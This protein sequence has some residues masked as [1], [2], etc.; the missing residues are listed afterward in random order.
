MAGVTLANVSVNVVGATTQAMG[1]AV[2]VAKAES[3]CLQVALLAGSVAD[4]YAN[5]R[6]YDGAAQQM[7]V[8]QE[9]VRY[10]QP[11]GSPLLLLNFILTAGQYIIVEGG[12]AGQTLVATLFNRWQ[13]DA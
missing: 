3:V 7:L 2:P 8:F 12:A 13:F 9:P 4:G 6:Y 10:R 1:A 5:V 11:G